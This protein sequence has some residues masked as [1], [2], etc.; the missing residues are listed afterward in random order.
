MN[1]KASKKHFERC[2]GW[3]GDALVDTIVDSTGESKW[4]V[5]WCAK[6]NLIN[7]SV[8]LGK[9]I[10]PMWQSSCEISTNSREKLPT[11]RANLGSKGLPNW[12]Y[13]VIGSKKREISYYIWMIIGVTKGFFDVIVKKIEIFLRKRNTK[14]Q[15]ICYMTKK[16]VA[17]YYCGITLSI[18][19]HV[20]TYVIPLRYKSAISDKFIVL[21]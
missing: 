14:I 10:T 5:R 13:E 7:D 3:I 20:D 1:K 21:S 19:H 11:L 2:N 18:E 8:M 6:Q 12:Y 9:K 15:Y 16:G 4:W 17:I